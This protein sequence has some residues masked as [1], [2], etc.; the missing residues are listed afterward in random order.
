MMIL[1]AMAVPFVAVLMVFAG[2]AGW[3]IWRMR[4]S[5]REQMEGRR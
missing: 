2:T 3:L 1:K 5:V 4:K